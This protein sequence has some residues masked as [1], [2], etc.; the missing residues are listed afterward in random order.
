MDTNQ[1]KRNQYLDRTNHAPYGAIVA[2]GL[3]MLGLLTIVVL[4]GIF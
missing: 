1:L 2:V 3:V 4:L